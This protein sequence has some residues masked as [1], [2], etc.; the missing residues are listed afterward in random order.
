MSWCAT[1]ILFL[2][3]CLK[4]DAGGFLISGRCVIFELPLPVNLVARAN[5]DRREI[6][7]EDAANW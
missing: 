3:S 7:L 1:T 2:F 5:H 6:S 4:R